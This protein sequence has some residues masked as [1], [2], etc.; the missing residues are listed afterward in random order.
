MATEILTVLT[1]LGAATFGGALFAF[2]A[3]V[4]HALDRTPPGPRSRRCSRS[5]CPPRVHP[6]SS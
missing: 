4:M 1:A 3:F 6:W 5:T 2:S